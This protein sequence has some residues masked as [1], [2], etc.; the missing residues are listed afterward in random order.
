MS[1]HTP[2]PWWNDDTMIYAT[3]GDDLVRVCDTTAA[4]DDED[5]L[6]FEMEEANAERIVQCV[7]AH[8][9][10]VDALRKLS[11]TVEGMTGMTD[12]TPS[13]FLSPAGMVAFEA[14]KEAA[15]L[16]SKLEGGAK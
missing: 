16:L 7:N 10:L 9:E 12:E 11:W 6:P 14:N 15:A 2:E 5:R 4:D 3:V 8:D 13:P 1:K